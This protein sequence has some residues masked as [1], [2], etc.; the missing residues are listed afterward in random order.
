MKKITTFL[1]FNDQTEEAVNL[2]VSVFKD[3]KIVS[4]V[5]S[6]GDGPV[7]KGKVLQAIFQLNGEEFFATDGGPHFSF[8]EGM[9]LMV[10]CETQQEIDDL[11]EKLSEGGTK[12]QCGWLKDKFGVSWQIVPAVLGDMLANGNAEQSKRV[13]D[14]LLKMGK[15]EIEPLQRAYEQG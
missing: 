4:L 13:M 1:M 15:L 10:N 12:D 6:E 11:W 3:S 14:V 9:S 8:S 2:Y 7:P 5:R